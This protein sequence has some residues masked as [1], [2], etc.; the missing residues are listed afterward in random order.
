MCAQ[1]NTP[2]E[3]P[4]MN[5]LFFG[6]NLSVL[7]EHI[8]DESVDL[9]YLDP[10][11]KSNQNYNVLFT[12]QDGTRSAAQI[13]AFRDTWRWD[14]AAIDA[15]Q[16]M[17]ERGGKVSE[18]MQAF[19]TLLGG[20]DMLAYLSMMAP[21]LVELRRVLKPTGSLYLHCDPT[22][23][24]YLKILLD[25]VFG[26]QNFRNEV[27]WKRTAAHSAAKRW[28][29]VHDTLLF[30]TRSEVYTWNTLLLPHSTE[31]TS[32]YKRIDSSERVLKIIRGSSPNAAP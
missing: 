24:H 32:R 11:F 1:H 8:K 15:F 20:N 13:K 21:R 9:V 2:L 30:Y 22:A 29:D 25:S 6:D 4:I 28:N 27:I 3:R 31:Y 16:H 23:S 5:Q 12:E 18:A 10:P 19:H 7:R 17:V 14:S 26:P